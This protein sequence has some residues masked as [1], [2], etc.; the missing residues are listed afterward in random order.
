M[1]AKYTWL[2]TATEAQVRADLVALMAGATNV[3]SLSASCDKDF[4]SIVANTTATN[5]QISDAAASATSQV[6]RSLNADGTT[7][8]YAQFTLSAGAAS[9]TGWETWNAVTHAGTNQTSSVSTVTPG[10][11]GITLSYTN[12]GSIYIFST[13]RYLIISP[14]AALQASYC[15][16]LFEFSRDSNSLDITYPCHALMH[17]G[18]YILAPANG[19]F[20]I[21]RI[22][23]NNATGDFAGTGVTAYIGTMFNTNITAMSG[24]QTSPNYGV[25]E[26]PYYTVLPIVLGAALSNGSFVGVLGKVQGGILMMPNSTPTYTKFDEMVIGS[27]TYVM[28]GMAQCTVMIPKA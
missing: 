3:A 19:S 13:P 28:I 10:T 14:S 22:K 11:I 20:S 16:G 23:K 2:A 12:P 7:Y 6:L 4:T 15:V 24:A 8:K 1:Y 25:G 9:L 26:A 21:S 18:T 27:T 17:T 5:W